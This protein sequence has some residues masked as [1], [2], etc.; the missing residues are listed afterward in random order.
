MQRW[1]TETAMGGWRVSIY[2]NISGQEL[3][4]CLPQE[5]NEHSCLSKPRPTT[6]CP[7]NDDDDDDGDDDDD[8]L[9]SC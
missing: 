5:M 6:S 3:Q 8:E 2:E 7:A 4:E 9:W 1:K